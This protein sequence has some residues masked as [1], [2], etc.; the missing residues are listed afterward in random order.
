MASMATRAPRRMSLGLREYRV[1][2]LDRSML[3]MVLSNVLSKWSCTQDLATFQGRLC[4][5]SDGLRWPSRGRGRGHGR[6]PLGRRR[7]WWYRIIILNP[8]NSGACSGDG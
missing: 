8:I 7:D 5:R 3:W 1:W 4:G 6:A 2:S